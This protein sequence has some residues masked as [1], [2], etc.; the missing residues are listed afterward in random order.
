MASSSLQRISAHVDHQIRADG[1]RDLAHALE[2]DEAGIGAGAG[3]EDPRLDLLGPLLNEV[4]VDALGLRV[5]AVEA[6]VEILAG[7]GRLRAVGQVAAV[8]EIHAEN[9]VARLEQ[10]EIHGDIGLGAGM[11]LDVGVLGAEELLG[12]LDGEVLDLVHI[13]TAA[14]VARA[15]IALGV[16]VGQ[17][18]AHGLHDGG[19]YEV[20]RGDQLDM[21]TLALKLAHHGRV[22]LRVL[23]LDGLIAHRRSSSLFS[24]YFRLSILQDVVLG[25]ETFSQILYFRLHVFL[26]R[27][28]LISITDGGLLP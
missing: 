10:R 14:V 18:A 6:G 20:L 24:L 4:V 23:P 26:H 27:D 3:D 13:L 12:P 22:D 2:V 17:M 21:I 16:L 7:D 25:N 11:G 28:K 1:V 15:G 8:A 19:G 5:D 9:G